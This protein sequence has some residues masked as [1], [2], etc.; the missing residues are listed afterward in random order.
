MSHD[1]PQPA[2]KGIFRNG[3]DEPLS[4][5][6]VLAEGYRRGMAGH[7]GQALWRKLD[8]ACVG[9]RR[10]GLRETMSR[11]GE[12]LDTSALLLEGMMVRH[13]SSA[14]GAGNRMAV[15][16]QV[17]GDFVDL[18]GLPLKYLDHDVSTLTDAVVALFPHDRLKEIMATSAE[19]ATTLWS[20]TMIDAA[21]HRRWIYRSGRFRALAAMADFICEL[22]T[23]LRAANQ[24]H[25]GA[26]QMPLTQTDLS[27][28]LGL[29][30]VHVSRISREL[31]EA[32]L[33][34]IRDSGVQIH[35][36]DGLQ[37][38]SGFDPTY[39]YPRV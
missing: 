13:V 23:R 20:L 31:R 27:E 8:A 32:N 35:N 19:D 26:F 37:R 24:E 11:A 12:R 6:A 36:W 18:H 10:L 1:D 39:L 28:I 14:P 30:T 5:P 16:I 25:D 21:I 29:S 17:P 2:S 9:T 34:T 3:K 4:A 15:S 7:I 22:R 38:L 33:C